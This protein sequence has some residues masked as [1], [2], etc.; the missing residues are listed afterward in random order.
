MLCPGGE[1]WKTHFSQK[2]EGKT[3]S[4]EFESHP[5]HQA[6]IVQVVEYIIG[7]DEVMGSNPVISTTQW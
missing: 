2:E 4:C 3:P 1:I 5:G 7:N 6:D